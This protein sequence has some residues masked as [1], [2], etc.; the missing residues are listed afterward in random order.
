MSSETYT[1]K[2]ISAG[3]YVEGTVEALSQEEASFKLKE[4]KIIITKIIRTRKKAAENKKKGGGLSLFKKKIK[5]EDVMI[6]SKQFATMVKAGLPI[7]NVLGMLRDQLEHPELKII[8]EDI[9]KSL[10]GGLTLS[11]CFEKY[12]KV[13]DNIYVNL[14]KAGEASGKLDVFLIKLVDSL[15]K[16]ERVKKKIKGAL[17]Y[18][19]VM[20]VTAITVMVF[21]LIKVV[22]IFAEMYEGMGIPLPTPTA[23]IMAASNFI[24]GSGGMITFI[25]IVIGYTV[26]KY[27]T[28]KV[29]AIRYKW[30]QRILKMPVFGD[31][32]L[33]SLIAR[34]SLIMGNLSGAGVNLLESIEIAKQV[35]NNDVVTLALENVKKGVFSGDTLT[36]LFMKEPTFPPTFSQLISVGEQTG[37]LDEMFTSVANYYEE[38]FDTA[39]DNMS[40][41]IEPIM[42]VFMGVMIGGLMI[43]MYSPIFNVGAIIGQ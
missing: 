22:P 36:K 33:K 18:P 37:N 40:S 7:L 30:H 11:K 14:I 15:E 1:Y 31:M 25:T 38:E 13:F 34:V 24:R 21:M 9:R 8:V 19:A 12:P 35:S 27:L 23:V 32:I 41:L 42:I 43:A 20:F 10:E 29:P 3:K 4:Q 16:R 26:F 17:M 5:P 28:T 39:V 2:G 6:F